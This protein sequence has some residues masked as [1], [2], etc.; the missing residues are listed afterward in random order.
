MSSYS[1]LRQLRRLDRSSSEFP[2]QVT[3][4]LYGEDY[5][6]WVQTVRDKDLVGLVDY[7]DKVRCHVP[8][9]HTLLKPLQALDN[10]DPS[11]SAFRKCLRELRHVCGTRAILPT[12]FLLSSQGLT[13]GHQ[14]VSPTSSG[15]VYEGSFNGKNV[16]V[17]RVRIYSKDDSK[18]ATKVHCRRHHFSA[19]RS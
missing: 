14:P 13:V 8:L 4:I 2:D 18:K 5:K 11:D 6:Q 3:D 12:L 10:L 1:P 9:L 19:C 16:C 17:K 15:D 7:L